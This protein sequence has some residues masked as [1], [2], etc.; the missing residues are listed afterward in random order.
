MFTTT[1][2]DKLKQ[3]MAESDEHADTIGGLIA[4]YK[5]TI[6]AVTHEIRNPLTLIYSSMQLIESEHPEIQN[7]RHW[8]ALH[9]DVLYMM[10]LL[11]DL[12]G[13]NNGLTLHK[14]DLNTSA[15]IKQLV[16]SF[17]ASSEAN[18]SV[19]LKDDTKTH[20]PGNNIHLR[21]QIQDNGCGIPPEQMD[22]IFKP[23]VTF[24]TGGTG[25]GLPLSKRIVEA[26]GGTLTVTS[27][28]ETGATFTILIP[29]C[30]D[31]SDT[32]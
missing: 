5:E 16:L 15:F 27:E 11:T 3:I 29:A 4:S 14:K 30:S 21:I 32:E 10:Q 26:H 20:T 23:F 25:L 9:Q 28:T 7:F 6:S 18:G 24:K 19:R 22:V 31:S 13:Y 8:N 2:L 1:N 12:S 17:A